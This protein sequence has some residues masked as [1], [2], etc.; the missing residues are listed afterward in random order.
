MKILIIST[1]YPPHVIGGA[2]KAAMQLAEALIHRGHVVVVV[3]LY[4]GSSEV[5][6]DRNGVRI[7]R[8]PMDNFYWPF[9][10]KEKPS[11][12]RRLA[13][14]I[15]EVWNPM[16]ARRIGRI[17]DAEKPDVRHREVCTLT[18]GL[19]RVCIFHLTAIVPNDSPPWQGQQKGILLPQPK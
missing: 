1:L 16:A 3:S 8:L 12:L 7:Y 18:L 10:R 4:P 15:R 5:V 9:G 19:P 17:L 14:H 6:E 13:W 11:I 2:E